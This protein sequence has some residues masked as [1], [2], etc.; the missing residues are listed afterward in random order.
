M[1]ELQ[2]PSLDIPDESLRPLEENQHTLIGVAM[3]DFMEVPD[4]ETRR[5]GKISYLIGMDFIHTLVIMCAPS[6]PERAMTVQDHIWR[7]EVHEAI[8][9]LRVDDYDVSVGGDLAVA[10]A[11]KEDWRVLLRELLATDV[12]GHIAAGWMVR[13]AVSRWPNPATRSS[14]SLNKAAAVIEEWATEN[15]LRGATKNNI[16]RRLWPAYRSVSHL[17]AAM[18]LCEEGG[19]DP[20]HPLGW[21]IFLGTAQWIL[22]EGSKIAPVRGRPGETFLSRE[23][24]WTIPEEFLQRGP[25]GEIG[26]RTWNTDI[27]SHDIRNHGGLSGR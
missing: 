24:A 19:I 27:R 15:R 18:Y 3:W 17:W 13:W 25:G 2:F 14:A 21:S 6:F 20:T 16:K 12:L 4:E 9:A 8:K 1:P 23:S 10:I 5:L 11:E 22:E 7:F 26:T